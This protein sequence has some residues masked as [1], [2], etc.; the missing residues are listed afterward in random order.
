MYI[1]DFDLSLTIY[2]IYKSTRQYHFYII[3]HIYIYYIYINIYIYI[4][5]ENKS[6][7]QIGSTMN[8]IQGRKEGRK[9]VK[10]GLDF[11]YVEHC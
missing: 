3:Y 7:K 6:L 5:C 1:E 8:I 2:I 9:E 4:T 10:R 11:C